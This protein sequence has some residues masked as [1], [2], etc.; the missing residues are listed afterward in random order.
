MTACCYYEH[1]LAAKRQ[2]VVGVAVIHVV[3]AQVLS[4]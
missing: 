1:P 4:L 3:L 2:A